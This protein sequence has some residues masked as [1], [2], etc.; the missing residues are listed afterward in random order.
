MNSPK[1]NK[2][3]N[4]HLDSLIDFI[5]NILIDEG[6]TIKKEKTT[7][8][9]AYSKRCDLIFSS[10]AAG[11]LEF[12]SISSS[13]GKN[14]NNRIEE[15]AGQAWLLKNACDGFGYVFVYHDITEEYK[16]YK[17]I[18]NFCR[19]L[20]MNNLMAYCMLIKVSGNNVEIDETYGLKQLIDTVT[21][22][23]ITDC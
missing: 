10:G 21:T 7:I 13:F 6:Y 18:K 12:K 14:Y 15:M 4:R 23:E 9:E 2:R 17:K 19:H 1:L 8:T 20:L 16:Y 5:A 11:I 22:Q 3:R